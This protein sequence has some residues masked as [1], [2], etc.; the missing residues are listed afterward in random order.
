MIRHT[1]LCEARVPD[2]P[3]CSRNNELMPPRWNTWA[4]VRAVQLDYENAPKERPVRL[5][6]PTAQVGDP[7][8]IGM[9]GVEIEAVITDTST[10]VLKVKVKATPLKMKVVKAKRVRSA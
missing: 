7:V 3:T 10:A 4:S 9:S 2:R 8:R 6:A 5:A 1:D